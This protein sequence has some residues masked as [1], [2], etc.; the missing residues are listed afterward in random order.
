M[1]KKVRRKTVILSEM[2]AEFVEFTAKNMRLSKTKSV[3]FVIQHFMVL[4]TF[5]HDLH[6][7]SHGVED[8]SDLDHTI[9]DHI[10]TGSFGFMTPPI[11]P[12]SPSPGDPVH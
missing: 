9:F 6:C 8:E 12:P 1:K 10:A 2:A 7:N 3:D 4:Y 11:S 5:M